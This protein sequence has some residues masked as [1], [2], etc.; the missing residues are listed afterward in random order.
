[1]GL[2]SAGTHPTEFLQEFE[3]LRHDIESFDIP[4]ITCLWHCRVSEALLNTGDPAAALARARMAE[5]ALE[6]VLRDDLR[7]AALVLQAKALDQLQDFDELDRVAETGI[8]LVEAHRGKASGQY[9]QSGYLRDRIAL[10]ALGV[11]A[12]YKRG[13]PD[14][15]IHRA[16]LS[17]CRMSRLEPSDRGKKLRD[18]LHAISRRIDALH[19]ASRPI[20]Q[21]LAKRRS[22]WD[23]YLRETGGALMTVPQTLAES[24]AALGPRE[25]V[26][27]FYWVD[28]T[29][30]LQLVFDRRDSALEMLSVPADTR[31][32]LD[33]YAAN[34]ASDAPPAAFNIDD[35]DHFAF[36]WPTFASAILERAD[37]LILSPHRVLHRIPFAAMTVGS[38]PVIARWTLRHAPNMGCLLAEPQPETR[39]SMVAVGIREYSVPG[40]SLQALKDAVPEAERIGDLYRAAGWKVEVLTGDVDEARIETAAADAAVLHLAC[41]SQSV[42]DDLP[43]ESHLF[44]SRTRMD[45][46]EIP[47]CGLSAT[48]VV[49]SA[50]SSGQRAVSG[51]KLAELP[52][53]DLN[54]LQAAFITA[55]ARNL[56]AGLFP[57]KDYAASRIMPVFHAALLNGAP[58]DV[59]LAEAIRGYLKDHDFGACLGHAGRL[60]WA[61]FFLT[62]IGPY[63]NE[64]KGETP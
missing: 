10:Y 44:L 53:D 30:L 31:D 34:L 9:I 20:D 56:L 35:V 61:P 6:H 49:L 45:G 40:L 13:D 8:A 54:G 64:T 63:Q 18:D 58:A 32:A 57:V 37:R 24:Q 25:A 23:A 33:A 47:L 7:I 15:L 21:L 4:D 39:R 12:A 26:I 11:R 60:Y 55:G 14:A 22:L 3:A 17:K 1:L 43:L 38:T 29:T 5:K 51:R 62:A 41:H 50:C 48:T 59:A 2:R 46:L 52:G 27:Y 16:E 19:A 28:R 42:D 36:L